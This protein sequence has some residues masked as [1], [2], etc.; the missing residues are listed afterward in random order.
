MCYLGDW[1]WLSLMV[2][3]NVVLLYSSHLSYKH[4]IWDGAFNQ[5]LPYVQRSIFEYD[6]YR[7]QLILNA[8]ESLE[9]E[10]E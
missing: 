4:G 3:T 6:K 8:N 10:D 1:F 9:K 5:F 2:I 7:A